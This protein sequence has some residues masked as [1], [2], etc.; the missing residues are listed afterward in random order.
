MKLIIIIFLLSVLALEMATTTLGIHDICIK[1]ENQCKGFNRYSLKLDIKCKKTP[2][3]GN[4]SY[5]CESDYC[6]KNKHSCDNILSLIYLLNS[7]NRFLS[8]ENKLK[9]YSY[10]IGS[11]DYCIGNEHSLQPNHVCINGDGCSSVLK[12]PF[13]IGRSIT[14][15]P[16]NCPCP[17][18]HT[19][20]CGKKYC[21]VNSDACEVFNKTGSNYAI[22]SC[23]N[24]NQIIKKILFF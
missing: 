23:G 11:I 24:N 9:K 17:A 3:Q 20:N 19:F 22:K 1:K 5:E 10:L 4:F 16:I 18:K 7:Y 6:A 12:S 8:I 13:R 14:K 21:T 2:C 15:K